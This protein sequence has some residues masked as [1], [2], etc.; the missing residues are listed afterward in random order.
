[1]DDNLG[2]IQ[3]KSAKSGNFM[4]IAIPVTVFQV[5]FYLS[6]SNAQM[7]LTKIIFP[8]CTLFVVLFLQRNENRVHVHTGLKFGD[9]VKHYVQK[10]KIL[11][12]GKACHVTC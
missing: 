1:M 9:A 4:Q 11:L 10:K 2:I 8:E 6:S 5:Y 7:F 12:K 3:S